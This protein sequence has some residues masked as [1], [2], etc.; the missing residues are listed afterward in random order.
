MKT[1][2]ALTCVGLIF[3]GSVLADESHRFCGSPSPNYF[4]AVQNAVAHDFRKHIP[5]GT[6]LTGLSTPT[7]TKD[8]ADWYKCCIVISYAQQDE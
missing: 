4:T 2:Y 7:C 5:V 1:A 3:C 8:D 6:Y